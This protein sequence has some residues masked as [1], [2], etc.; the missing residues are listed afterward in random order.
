ML[1]D[2]L[3]NILGISW[4]YIGDSGYHGNT[5]VIPSGIIWGYL[6]AALEIQFRCLGDNLK[7]LWGYLGDTFGNNLGIS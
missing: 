6:M 7:I 3:W 4:E 1:V 5:L 2:D